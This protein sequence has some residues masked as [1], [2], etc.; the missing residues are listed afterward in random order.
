MKIK[1]EEL[2]VYR[3]ALPGL[4]IKEEYVRLNASIA[5]NEMLMMQATVMKI[6]LNL[7][8]EQH[9]NNNKKDKTDS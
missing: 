3:E 9:E 2:D 6:K 5:Q 8:R 7:E 4:R 1:E